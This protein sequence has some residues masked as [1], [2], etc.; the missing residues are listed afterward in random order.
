MDDNKYL[1]TTAISYSNGSHH[2]GHV[3]ESIL[4][5]FINKVY[6]IT[7]N[8]SKFLKGTDEYDKKIQNKAQENKI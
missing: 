6:K 4:A 8:K 3:Y 2:I 7:G 5:D 1:V